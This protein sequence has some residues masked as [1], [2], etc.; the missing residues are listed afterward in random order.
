MVHPD[1]FNDNLSIKRKPD[2][3]YINYETKFVGQVAKY[4]VHG[5]KF[6][7]LWTILPMM[8]LSGSIIDESPRIQILSSTASSS[9]MTSSDNDDAILRQI[10]YY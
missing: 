10:T 1:N 7:I 9:V 8:L 6:A 3:S 2:G 4:Y 5:A